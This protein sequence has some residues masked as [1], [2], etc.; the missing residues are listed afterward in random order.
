MATNKEIVED[1]YAS[2]STG[3]VP[4]VLGA[5]APDMEWINA[6]G[7][8]LLDGPV[9]GPQAILD[10][11][12][13]HLGDIGDEF[14]VFP[15]TIVA[16]GNTVMMDGTYRW[17]HKVSGEPAEVKCAHVSTLT[18]GRL[19]AFQQHVDTVKVRELLN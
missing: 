7:F 19:T 1:V 6:E 17:K 5:M 3:D 12:F 2:F 15:R 14:M 13:M 16:E 18:D 10:E 11:E 9:I 8:P 4:A